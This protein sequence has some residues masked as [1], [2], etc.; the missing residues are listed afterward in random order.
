[1][2]L[3][4]TLHLLGRHQLVSVLAT[5]VDFAL[6][7]ASVRFL[8]VSPVT[9][10]VIGASFGAVA[11]FALGRHWTFGATHSHPAQQALRYALVATLSL[12][13][14]AFGV[15]LLALE[16]GL[17]YV[18]A[19]AITALLV[20]WLWNFPMHRHFVFAPLRSP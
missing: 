2:P 10:T 6:M 19:R 13:W 16:L 12:G 7:I 20:G 9:A 1:M 15:W 17:Q 5:L 8:R 11:S 18:A 3:L 4:H 14:N